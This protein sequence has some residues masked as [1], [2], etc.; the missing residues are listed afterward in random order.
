M[1][2][3]SKSSRTGSIYLITLIT[4][5]VIVSMVL[6]GVSLRTSS[7]A[8]STLIVEM[9]ESSNSVLDATEYAYE[10]ITIDPL[11][12]LTA[13]AGSIFAPLTMGDV[14]YTSSVVD[15][16]TDAAPTYNTSTYRV[17]VETTNT[18]AQ[19][20]AYIDVLSFE[21]DYEAY[22]VSLGAV[23]YW[24]LDET[25]STVLASEP[26]KNKDGTYQDPAVAGLDYNEEAGLI[27]VLNKSNDHVLVP[28]TGQFKQADGSISFWMRCDGNNKWTNYSIM[29]M[30]YKAGGV[31]AFN[32]VVW[33]YGISMYLE[34]DGNYKFGNTVSTPFDLITPGQWH[35]VVT[36]WGSNGL[37]IYVDGSR[38]A[39]KNSLNDGV[40]T[41][42]GADGGKQPVLIGGGYRMSFGSYPQDGFVGSVSHV[43]YYKRQLTAG[44][45]A[46]LAAIKPDRLQYTLVEDSWVRVY[47]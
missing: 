8:S 2:M 22:V 18:I 26:V 42:D 45:V 43:A 9:N 41:A 6:I 46:A 27:P 39:K 37:R 35:H 1:D 15:K 12:R 31:P 3:Y 7:N 44:E 47:E 34:E 33:G 32:I 36:T 25:T 24:A 30:L 19:S 5:A 17:K 13:Q 21:M 4:V 40:D 23:M 10:V 29:G 11:W 14:S 28:W 20:A 38:K 16:D